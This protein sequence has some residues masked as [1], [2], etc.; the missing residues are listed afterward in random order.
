MGKNLADREERLS[1]SGP[2]PLTAKVV[3][4]RLWPV[5][6]AT[7][8]SPA[9]RVIA[10]VVLVCWSAALVTC[11]HFCATRGCDRTAKSSAAMS[12]Q[13]HCAKKA[14]DQSQTSESPCG[15]SVCFTKQPLAAE[16]DF[17]SGLQPSFSL[18]FIIGSLVVAFETPGPAEVVIARRAPPRDWVFTP[19][20][21]L[22]PAL[23]NL[24]PPVFI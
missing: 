15:N 1:Q 19:E 18:A 20:V 6:T 12:C 16:K 13:A 22:G 7:K 24:A 21:S 23:R 3:S 11:W 9:M 8:I 4:T 17:A 5:G 10:S 2:V 14:G